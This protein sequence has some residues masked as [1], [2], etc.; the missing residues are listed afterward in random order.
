MSTN[1]NIPETKS[2]YDV[3]TEF[4]LSTELIESPREGFVIFNLKDAGL[5]LPF[6]SP[7]Y[8]PDFYSFL[9][10]KDGAGHYEIDDKSFESQSGMLYFTNPSNYR[11]FGWRKIEDIYLVTFDENFLK[12][13]VDKNIYDEFPF[14]LTETINPKL[15]TTEFYAT[16]E[17]L[18]LEIQEEYIG[19]SPDK[20]AIIGHL[21]GILLYRIKDYFWKDYDPIYEGNRSSQIVKSFK[22][23]LEKHYREIIDGNSENIYKVQDYAEALHLNANYLGNVIKTKTG[24]SVSNWISNKTMLE[25]KSLL[26]NSTDSIKEISYRLKFSELAHFSNYFKKYA[27]ISPSQYRKEHS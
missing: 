10:I 16:S 22:R 1:V 9:F 11:K 14:L 4:G 24:K 25:A 13:Y 6:E 5:D 20:Y 8:R 26:A 12:K 21:L 7:A 17:Q 15:A 2:L 3:Y 19:S 27:G 23:L 18:Y